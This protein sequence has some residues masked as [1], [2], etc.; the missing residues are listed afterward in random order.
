MASDLTPARLFELVWES[1]ADILGTAAT[2]ALLGRAASRAALRGLDIS[3]EG[4]VYRYR[5]PESW[6]RAG[7]PDALS[8][9]RALAN[10]LAPLLQTMS[11]PVVARRLG[12]VAPLRQAGIVAVEEVR[13]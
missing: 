13:E 10:E 5:L 9:L 6:H 11:G 1:M 7:D 8:L 3:R 2:A 12:Q 4:L